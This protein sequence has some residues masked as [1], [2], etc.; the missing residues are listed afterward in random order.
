MYHKAET[1]RGRTGPAAVGGH[2]RLAFPGKGPEGP[3]SCTDLTE[4]FFSLSTDG[5][6]G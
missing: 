3:Y 2:P 4:I 5:A 6:D 1:N